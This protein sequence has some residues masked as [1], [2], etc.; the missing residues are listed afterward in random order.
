MLNCDQALELISAK[1]DNALT[2]ESDKLYRI[3]ATEYNPAARSS[4]K[5]LSRVIGC[6]PPATQ[7]PGQ[8]ITSMISAGAFLV[9]AKTRNNAMF[10][11]FNPL[12]LNTVGFATPSGR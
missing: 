12:I 3:S 5:L 10:F 11:L 6:P 2:A 1:V 4:R 9:F 8:T 7:P